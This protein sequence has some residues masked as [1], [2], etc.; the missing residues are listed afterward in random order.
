MG[1]RGFAPFPGGTNVFSFSDT[2]DMIRG[3]HDIRVGIGVR[4]NQ[5]N[6][7]TNGFQ[8]GYF[9]LAATATG[10]NAADLL[11]ASRSA[12]STIRRSMEL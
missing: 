10:D 5:M 8:D 3:N 12:R 4:L 11:L 6:V 9:L 7:M 1:D 2:F